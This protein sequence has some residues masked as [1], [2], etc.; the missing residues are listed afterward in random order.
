LNYSVVSLK[1]PITILVLSLTNISGISCFAVSADIQKERLT[2]T[3][4]AEKEDDTNVKA[5]INKKIYYNYNSPL[6]TTSQSHDNKTKEY[7]P[8]ITAL[9]VLLVSNLVV[10]LKIRLDSRETLRREITLSLIKLDKERLESFYDPIFTT[11]STNEDLFSSFGPKSFPEEDSLRNEAAIIWNKMVQN[12][13][14]QNNKMISDIISKKSHLIIEEDIL[15]NYLEFLKHA[16]SYEHFVK[17]PNS[18]HKRFKYNPEFIKN[19][20]RHRQN[21]LN[22]LKELETNLSQHGSKKRRRINN[23]FSLYF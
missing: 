9:I 22:K 19:V 15:G 7:L 8:S 18:I 21:I 14:L 1:I 12:V 16:Q 23:Q 17:Y 4:L 6:D 3:I 13:I 20:E 10:L 5:S 11:L 2:E